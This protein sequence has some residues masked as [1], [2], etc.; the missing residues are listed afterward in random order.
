MA[1]TPNLNP[2]NK[3]LQGGVQ[4]PGMTRPGFASG[5]GMGRTPVVSG[6]GQNVVLPG[7]PKGAYRGPAMTQPGFAGDASTGMLPGGVP[8]AGMTR[9][10]FASQNL[11]ATQQFPSTMPAPNSMA[12]YQAEKAAGGAF[13]DVPYEQWKQL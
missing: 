9:P 2:K 5:G 6:M 1:Y 11:G 12:Q 8:T 3:M 10:G 4:T 7:G 13:T